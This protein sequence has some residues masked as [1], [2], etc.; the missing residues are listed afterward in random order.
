MVLMTYEDL[1]CNYIPGTTFIF[2]NSY[3]WDF[4]KRTKYT[5]SEMFEDARTRVITFDNGNFYRH[6]N[7]LYEF[8]AYDVYEDLY[9]LFDELINFD[10]NN[11]YHLIIA[12]LKPKIT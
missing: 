7:S 4:S 3:R 1:K 12:F 9:K 11:L 8:E 2:I 6:I 5:I 10:E